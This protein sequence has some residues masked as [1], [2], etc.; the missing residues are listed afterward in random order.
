MTNWL[1]ERELIRLLSFTCNYV[2]SVQRGFLFL[3]VLGMGCV[4]LL[5]H[6]LGGH[7][8][9]LFSISRENGK[10]I[11]QKHGNVFHV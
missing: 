1:V 6:S 11:A 8:I 10:N 7:S 3:L 5:W 4:I 2:V 9:C